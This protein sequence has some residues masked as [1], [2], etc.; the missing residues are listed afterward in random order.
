MAIQLGCTKFKGK[1][2]RK[3]CQAVTI[4]TRCDAQ[5]YKQVVPRCL[6]PPFMQHGALSY[7]IRLNSSGLDK[8]KYP[9]K[10]QIEAANDMRSIC[11]HWTYVTA[12]SSNDLR[13]QRNS[14]DLK[15]ISL[16]DF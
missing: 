5:Y 4:S 14:K 9:S 15:I 12:F 11:Q 7:H 6:N 16:A 3:N 10:A 13:K 8:Y 2:D 1:R